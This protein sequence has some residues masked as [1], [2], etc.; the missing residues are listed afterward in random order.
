[1]VDAAPDAVR[2]AELLPRLV[3]IFEAVVLSVYTR[4]GKLKSGEPARM[5]R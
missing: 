3:M 5:W 2:D 4:N 1:M